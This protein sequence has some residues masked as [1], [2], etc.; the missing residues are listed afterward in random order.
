MVPS[1]GGT[2]ADSPAGAARSWAPGLR[3]EP[4]FGSPAG[5]VISYR[6]GGRKRRAA[7]TSEL[8]PLGRLTAPG[9]VHTLALHPRPRMPSFP[10]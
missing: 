7:V 6:A 5:E 3:R 10:N 9:L 2:L 8:P 1:A 4:E